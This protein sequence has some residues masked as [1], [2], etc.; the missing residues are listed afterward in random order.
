MIDLDA[1]LDPR[2]ENK[3]TRWFSRIGML[4]KMA[5]LAGLLLSATAMDAKTIFVNGA[6]AT[7]DGSGASWATAYKYLRDALNNSLPTDQIYVAK[8]TYYPD[9]DR[10]NAKLFGNREIAFEL[11]GQ[12]IYGGFAGTETNISQRNPAL[13]PTIL[14]GEIWLGLD[15]DI[16]F[17]SMH[18]I[19]MSENSTLDGIIV[20][21]GNSNGTEWWNYPSLEFYNQGAGCYVSS[22]KTLTL[23]GCTFRNN[24]AFTSGGGI[25]VQD[26]TGLVNATDCLFE[27]NLVPIYEN[28]TPEDAAGGAID[29]NVTA[30]NC[31]F[32]SNSVEAFDAIGG[33]SCSAE[34]GAIFGKVTATNCEFT[35]NTVTATLSSAGDNGLASGGAIS[36]SVQAFACNFSGNKSMAP[37]PLTGVAAGGAINGGTV[38]AV[39]CTFAAN[40]TTTGKI[41]V[42]DGSGEGGG[43]ALLTKGGNSSLVNCVFV[44]NTSGVRGGAIHAGTAVGDGS[45]PPDSLVISNCTFLD[46]GV[47]TTFKGAALSCGGQVRIMNNI[48][49]STAATA[50][51]FSQDNLIQ[52]ITGGLLRNTDLNYPTP[53]TV[54]QNVVKG[55]VA[56]GA[57]NGSGGDMNLGNSLATIVV[58][59]PLFFNAADPDGADNRWRTAD[60]GLRLTAGSSAIGTVRNPLVPTYRSFLAN[61]TLDI[62]SDGNTTEAIQ[63]DI[64]SFARVQNVLVPLP[65]ALA[66]ATPFLDMGAYEYGNLLHAPDISVEYPASTILVDGSATAVDFS[67][68]AGVTTTFVIK[69]LGTLLLSKLVITGDGVDIDSFRISQPAS[70]TVPVGSSTAFTV[71]FRPTATGMRN[72]QIHISSNDPDESPFDITLTGN[73]LLPDIAVETPV[74]TGLVDGASVV[75]F[76]A[77]GETL[78]L[79]KTFTLRNSGLGNLGIFGI[80]SSGTNVE[81]FTI[82]APGSTLL[83]PGATTTFNVTFSPSGIGSRTASIVIDNSDPNN[84][85]F[86]IDLSG[87]GVGIPEIVVSEP[88]GPE[89]VTGSKSNFGSVGVT[90][91]HSKTFVVKNTGSATLNNISVNLSGSGKFTKSKIGVTSLKPGTQ[92]KFSVTFKPTAV[93]KLSA[94]LVISSNDANESQIVLN[95][96]GTGVSKRSSGGATRLTRASTELTN[97]KRGESVTITRDS[98]GLKYLVLTVEKSQAPK[99]ADCKVEVSS[100]LTKWFSGSKYTTTLLDNNSVLRV[101]DD[102]PIK[103]GEKRY[104]RLK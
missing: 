35:D 92:A 57:T 60:D 39:N 18:V 53:S 82:T 84:G 42:N 94:T 68:L 88:F 49:W 22:G 100:N 72:A 26:D 73:S 13:N 1:P 98:E 41:N 99:L 63:A 75:D 74:G 12:K 5:A 36:G 86:L 65:P 10:L 59:A 51:G 19:V 31:R 34:G 11:V 25:K 87:S 80:S 21:G 27:Q 95:L 83:L 7:T 104:I 103:Q 66:V 20:E 85:S 6:A 81:N 93:G 64:A 78:T 4:Q 102:T 8:G 76:G 77:L 79:T 24:R 90:L 54:A 45:A 97:S 89:L 55:G 29:G 38:N 16:N 71:T 23:Q 69:N 48:F 58:G 46:N 15:P 43:G 47:A 91:L 67:A 14:S 33:G 62:D 30:T 70:T 96:T 61:D 32:I 101:R 3:F 44:K 50:G 56:A 17:S 28:F 2:L 37:P 9:D 52:V 40:T